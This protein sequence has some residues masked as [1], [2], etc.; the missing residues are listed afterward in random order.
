MELKP[1]ISA[2]RIINYQKVTTHLCPVWG[3]F[4]K[5]CSYVTSS[6]EQS[7]ASCKG[8]DNFPARQNGW[9]RQTPL[10]SHI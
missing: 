9:I 1:V 8:R 6:E 4:Y 3:C 7:L 5:N 2:L 10:W